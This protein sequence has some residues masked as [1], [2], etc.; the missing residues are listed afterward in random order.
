MASGP[1]KAMSHPDLMRPSSARPAR[2]VVAEG[3]PAARKMVVDFFVENDMRAVGASSRQDM[4]SHF[5]KVEP[6]LVIV[7]RLLGSNDGLDL[8]RD[9]RSL[10]DVPGVI[11]TGDRA[12]AVERA[13]GLELGAD[14]Y[15]TKPFGLR[16]LLA[17]VRAVLRGRAA[18]PKEPARGVYRFGGWH[19]DAP[20]RRL[21]N[22][23]G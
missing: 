12:D 20:R 9:I 14:D 6:D 15:I 23:E 10:S 19:L 18:R 7:D 17:R 4:I 22:P 2:I 8:L 11:I 3:D 13:I 16:E 21:T 1:G 5:A